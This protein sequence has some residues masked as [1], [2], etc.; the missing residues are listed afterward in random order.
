MKNNIEIKVEENG[1]SISDGNR[2]AFIE[3]GKVENYEVKDGHYFF[4]LKILKEPIPATAILDAAEVDSF[5]KQG[6]IPEL[7]KRK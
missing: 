7:L 5:F 1:Y 4:K 3:S 6:G 2:S